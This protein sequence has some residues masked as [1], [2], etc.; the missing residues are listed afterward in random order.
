M[1]EE[2]AGVRHRNGLN[3]TRPCRGKAGLTQLCGQRSITQGQFWSEVA[4]S[5]LCIA[6]FSKLKHSLLQ[7]GGRFTGLA[8]LLK[9]SD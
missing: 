3:Q 1:V 9:L 6:S 5:R 7:S 4:V 8:K 2:Q